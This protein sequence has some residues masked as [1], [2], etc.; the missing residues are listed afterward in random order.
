MIPLLALPL[1]VDVRI[2]AEEFAGVAVRVDDVI[3][4]RLTPFGV[5]ETWNSS[6]DWMAATPVGAAGTGMI[7]YAVLLL[8]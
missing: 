5:H 1:T 6:P 7:R 3:A 4:A 2:D 8:L